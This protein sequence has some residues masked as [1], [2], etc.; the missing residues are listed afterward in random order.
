MET[1]F[2]KGDSAMLNRIL[3]FPMGLLYV[4]VVLYSRR[5]LW[6]S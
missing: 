5:R 3:S 4:A 1:V 2:G 6:L